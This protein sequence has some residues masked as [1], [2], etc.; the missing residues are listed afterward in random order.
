MKQVTI[1]AGCRFNYQTRIGR[2]FV[3]LE[4]QG[5]IKR[6]SAQIQ[7]ELETPNRIV[8]YGLIAAVEQIKEPCELVFKTCTPVGFKTRK[9]PNVD[10]ILQLKNLVSEK[11]CVYSFAEISKAEIDT[12]T[13]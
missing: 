10:L 2:Y 3:A 7:G 8:I 5:T 1:Y 6:I 12:K 13:F 4:Y 11:G 9:S